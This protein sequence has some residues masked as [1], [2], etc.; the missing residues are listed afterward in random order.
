MPPLVALIHTVI[1]I[2]IWL[3]IGQAVLSWLIAF[4][5][6]NRHNRVV[7]MIEDFCEADHRAGAAPDSPD[8]C[9][10]S[11]GSTSAPVVLILLLV[12]LGRPADV[13]PIR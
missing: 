10:I 4:G 2:Y 13:D 9:P 3:L 5:I 1:S 6:V 12:L 7:G 8:H 11:A